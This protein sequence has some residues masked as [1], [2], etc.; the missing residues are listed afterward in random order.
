MLKIFDYVILPL[1]IVGIAVLVVDLPF[2][3]AVIGAYIGICIA[4]VL[5]RRRENK[6]GRTNG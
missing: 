2:V 6:E 1:I 4:I 5:R 3:P